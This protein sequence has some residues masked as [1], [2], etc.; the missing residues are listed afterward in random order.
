M[1]YEKKDVVA[2]AII[3]FVIKKHNVRCVIWCVCIVLFIIAAAIGDGIAA[4]LIGGL[5]AIPFIII[6]WFSFATYREGRAE[7]ETSSSLIYLLTRKEE[8]AMRIM[9]REFYH[10]REEIAVICKTNASPGDRGL[11]PDEGETN[12]LLSNDECGCVKDGDLFACRCIPDFCSE[13]WLLHEE[14]T[15]A[16]GAVGC[17]VIGGSYA[18]ENLVIHKGSKRDGILAVLYYHCS[19]LPGELILAIAD[20]VYDNEKGAIKTDVL[21]ALRYMS[22]YSDSFEE[23]LEAH[24]KFIL[25]VAKGG[26]IVDYLLRLFP[27]LR[28]VYR[29]PSFYRWSAYEMACT[30]TLLGSAAN[31]VLKHL[32]EDPEIKFSEVFHEDGSLKSSGLYEGDDGDTVYAV[33]DTWNK[34]YGF[35]Q[36]N[37]E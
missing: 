16:K 6:T 4:G 17:E 7:I 34:K 15:I 24:V 19:K 5:S 9:M 22:R 1:Y 29:S 21:T 14:C 3:D 28:A 33:I 8:Q 10:L 31:Y 26:V 11:I 32:E 13:P 23:N 27:Y 37:E 12:D 2:R 30:S 20:S 36:E 35:L 25:E 18:I